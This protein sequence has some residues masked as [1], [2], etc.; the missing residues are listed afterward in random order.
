MLMCLECGGIAYR[1]SYFGTVT[2]QSCGWK[3]SIKEYEELENQRK[4]VSEMNDKF[5]VDYL[6]DEKKIKINL[7]EEVWKN[8]DTVIMTRLFQEEF[9][10]EKQ[11]V[12]DG[13]PVM[14]E[15]AAEKAKL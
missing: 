7:P 15:K 1:N 2:C 12:Q 13:L 11:K 3:V 6:P 10:V 5:Q 14:I 4:E 8:I 9:V